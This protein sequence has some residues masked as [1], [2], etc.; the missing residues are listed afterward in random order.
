M[1]IAT[2]R[3]FA[4]SF[5]TNSKSNGDLPSLVVVLLERVRED[6]MESKKN[7]GRHTLSAMYCSV[8]C[9]NYNILSMR[10]HPRMEEARLWHCGLHRAVVASL[11]HS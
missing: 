7:L 1:L 3:D 5:K 6:M 2:F 9:F 8:W 11:S 10:D 4:D